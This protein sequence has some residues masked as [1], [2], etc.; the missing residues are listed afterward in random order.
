MDAYFS[1]VFTHPEDESIEQIGSTC[2]PIK[3]L[4]PTSA[5]TI[6]A[7]R[8]K[9]TYDRHRA[10]LPHAF[11]Y[12]SKNEY[13]W[14]LRFLLVDSG[15]RSEVCSASQ[16]VHM[17]RCWKKGR[18]LVAIARIVLY[19]RP[20][21]YNSVKDMKKAEFM[22]PEYKLPEDR[23]EELTDVM[24]KSEVNYKKKWCLKY[25]LDYILGKCIVDM[26]VKPESEAQVE[27]EALYKHILYKFK[28]GGKMASFFLHFIHFALQNMTPGEE[29]ILR[30]KLWRLIRQKCVK[31]RRL[32]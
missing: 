29:T 18:L 3:R 4:P 28:S 13:A 21:A 20:M 8:K 2:M 32:R 15:S 12:R 1:T 26:K 27:R 14:L 31:E 16:T 30:E 11:E 7:K 22:S 6:R 10:F 19:L 5:Y 24:S 23:Y 17:L 9:Y 25:L